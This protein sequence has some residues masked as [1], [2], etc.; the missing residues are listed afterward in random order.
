[1]KKSAKPANAAEVTTLE[2]LQRRSQWVDVWKRL[3]KNKLAMA[4]LIIVAIMVLMSVFANLLT[5]Y[6]PAA[7]DAAN[8]FQNPSLQHLFGTDQYGRDIFCRM[9][10]GGRVSLL[11]SVMGTGIAL[12]ASTFLGACAGYFGGKVDSVIMRFMDVIMA[13][14]VTLWAICIS[15]MLGTGI[16]Q[17]GLAISVG[18]L[19]PGCRMIRA[20]ILTIRKQEYVEAAESSGSSNFRI[21]MK[22]VLPNCLA[23][24]IVDTTLRLGQN[25]LMISSLSF[26]GLG[27]QPPTP[28]WGSMLNSGRQYIRDFYPLVVFPGVF[29]ML[30]MFGF[31][32]FGDGLRDA[33][34]PKLKR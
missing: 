29:V 30:T 24:I 3:R 14:P 5:P 28:E 18:G 8:R 20:T 25:I 33:L 17:T 23:P 4:G 32:V 27:I 11:V 13:V 26:I 1:M 31:N 34:D 15:T 16:W 10:Y 22:H 21:I 9:L 19:A 6:D 2:D 7:Q 12:L